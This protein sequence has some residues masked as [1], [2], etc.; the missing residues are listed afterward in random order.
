MM[1][2]VWIN[3]EDATTAFD[4]QG[5]L[6]QIRVFVDKDG[7]SFVVTTLSNFDND[8]IQIIHWDEDDTN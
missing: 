5:A 1:P 6:L 4:I 3:W 8:I 2:Q 7:N